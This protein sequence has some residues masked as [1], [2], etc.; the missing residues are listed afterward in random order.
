MLFLLVRCNTPEYGHFTEGEKI[1]VETAPTSADV[2]FVVEEKECNNAVGAK[3]GQLAWQIET[4]LKTKGEIY[5][6]FSVYIMIR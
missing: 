5:I 6:P 4:F 2:V 1:T 3:L